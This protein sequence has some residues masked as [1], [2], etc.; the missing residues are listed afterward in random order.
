MEAVGTLITLHHGCMCPSLQEAALH[1][2]PQ[3]GVQYG[4]GAGE[5]GRDIAHL[6]LR[7]GTGAP[8]VIPAA[9][10][11]HAGL[12]FSALRLSRLLLN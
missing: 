11:G 4:A 5:E 9:P 7:S 8:G 3:A 10:D 6:R 1:L 2:Y 12:C